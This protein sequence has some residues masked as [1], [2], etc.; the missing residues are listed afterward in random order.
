[1]ERK[2]MRKRKVG[3]L[4]FKQ[5]FIHFIYRKREDSAKVLF[6]IHQVLCAICTTVSHIC[7]LVVCVCVR[8]GQ[9]EASASSTSTT[10]ST[11]I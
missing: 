5:F 2:R 11:S 4:S 8:P 6:E 1:M 9:C 7:Q 10:T 3:E